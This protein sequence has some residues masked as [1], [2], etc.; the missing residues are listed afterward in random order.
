MEQS[1]YDAWVD[2]SNEVGCGA[3]CSG[4]DPAERCCPEAEK[5]ICECNSNG[6]VTDIRFRGKNLPI[7]VGATLENLHRL[8][9]LSVLDFAHYSRVE[10]LPESV[11]CVS[12]LPFVLFANMAT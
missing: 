4:F 11:R 9:K 3:V 2:F 12:P 5:P 7:K 8:T 6:F 10:G 1:Q